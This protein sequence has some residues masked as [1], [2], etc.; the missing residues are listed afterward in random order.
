MPKKGVSNNPNGRNKGVPNKVTME[1]KEAFK[2]L[3]ELN[4]PNM[5]S[6]MQDIADKDPAKALSLCA[7]LA[8]FVVPKLARTETKVTGEITH[9]GLVIERSTDKTT[10]ET[11]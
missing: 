8:E 2:N 4:T 3:I 9:K 7:D 11:I 6:W 10:P 5:I 1:I